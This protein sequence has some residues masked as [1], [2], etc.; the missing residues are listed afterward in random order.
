ME[1]FESSS[2]NDDPKEDEVSIKAASLANEGGRRDHASELCW[3]LAFL[4]YTREACSS[5]RKCG[6]GSMRSSESR[7]AVASKDKGLSRR[8]STMIG[9]DSH[10]LQ[11]TAHGVENLERSTKL[12]S[13]FVVGHPVDGVHVLHQPYEG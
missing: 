5:R 1:A 3:R 12:T 4:L 8:V 10:V 6:C 13:Y 11:E 2:V 7:P 9:L